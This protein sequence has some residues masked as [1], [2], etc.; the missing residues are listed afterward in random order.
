MRWNQIATAWTRLVVEVVSPRSSA[1]EDGAK[2]G[3]TARTGSFISGLY[4]ENR[5][6]PYNRDDR[7]ERADWSQHLSC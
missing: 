6:T 1:P 5:M 7:T 3:D 2:Q 4:E